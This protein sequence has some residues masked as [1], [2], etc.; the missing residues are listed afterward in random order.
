MADAGLTVRIIAGRVDPKGEK[1]SGEGFE[2]KHVGTGRYH[3]VFRPPYNNVYG[4][5]A[6]Q[7]GFDGGGNDPR[8]NAFLFDVDNG[9]MLIAT[10]ESGGYKADRAFTFIVVGVGG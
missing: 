6:T 3:I 1:I 10:G 5:S 4:A 8:D 7:V 9:S 2:V